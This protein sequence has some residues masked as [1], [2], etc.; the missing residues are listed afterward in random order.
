MIYRWF[1]YQ[2]LWCSG[3]FPS[4]PH[5]SHIFRILSPCLPHISLYFLYLSMFPTYFSSQTGAVLQVVQR[6]WPWACC[7]T[8]STARH[9]GWDLLFKRHGFWHFGI[10]NVNMFFCFPFLFCLDLLKIGNIGKPIKSRAGFQ[11]RFLQVDAGRGRLRLPVPWL[12]EWLGH[13]WRCWLDPKFFMVNFLI[14]FFSL[15]LTLW[16]HPLCRR[17]CSPLSTPDAILNAFHSARQSNLG[18]KST[19]V[20]VSGSQKLSGLSRREKTPRVLLWLQGLDFE[21]I[22]PLRFICT[23]YMYI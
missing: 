5:I 18:H 19:I 21:L 9:H 10:N 7:R 1:S 4:I 16:L 15:K 13:F 14:T 20:C 17:R 3:S 6:V 23:V 11:P 22:Y 8:T 2:T 12:G